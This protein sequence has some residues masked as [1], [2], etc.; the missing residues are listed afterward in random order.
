MLTCRYFE[1]AK[2]IPTNLGYEWFY[3]K[4]VSETIVCAKVMM[5]KLKVGQKILECSASLE[6]LFRYYRFVWTCTN[7]I[8]IYIYIQLISNLNSKN[9]KKAYW[10]RPKISER[11]GCSSQILI[12][13][14]SE[15]NPFSIV[16]N[17]SFQISNF[18][19]WI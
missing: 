4:E 11:C 14:K 15:N 10:L 2:N 17:S 8:Y 13:K 5:Q 3:S 18:N 16:W 9:P 6:L 1:S 19:S 7:I 12:L